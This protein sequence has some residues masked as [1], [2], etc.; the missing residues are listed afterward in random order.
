[1]HV[2]L[3]AFCMF[4]CMHACVCMCVPMYVY[5]IKIYE[6]VLQIVVTSACMNS[7]NVTITDLRID[8]CKY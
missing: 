4:G 8:I 2:S 6:K 7:N 1:M 5:K 3:Y